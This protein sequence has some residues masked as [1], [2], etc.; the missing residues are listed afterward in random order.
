MERIELA[1]RKAKEQRRSA[2]RPRDGTAPKI[3]PAIVFSQTRTINLSQPHLHASHIITAQMHHP[4]TDVYRSL[5]AQVLQAL[6]SSGKTT[7]G[8]TSA[9]H[10]EGKTL[11]A[12][13]LAIAMA[14]DVN[15]TVLLVDADLRNPC[16]AECLGIE[17]SLGLSDCLIGKGEIGDCLIN[18]G[19]ERL[20]ILPARSRIG[21]SAELLS[22]PQM[23]R[24]ASELKDRYS[25]RVIIYDL[26]PVLTVGDTI[27][28]L[29]SVDAT[30]LVV[31]DGATQATEL[32]HALEL[33]ASYNLIGTVLNAI[34]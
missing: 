4:L 33:L 6:N 22:S 1:L 26:P 10:G 12:I 28:F 14:M 19:I 5:R 17:P 13:N 20:S 23:S 8:I 2:V 11:T 18:P 25:D 34:P 15:H 31:R 29:P 16:I 24:L 7:I 27:G 21:N 32:G 9:N 3:K 30:L